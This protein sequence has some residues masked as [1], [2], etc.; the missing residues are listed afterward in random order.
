[1]RGQGRRDR[2][3]VRG[4][5]CLGAH[6]ALPEEAQRA[7]PFEVDVDL[8]LDLRAAGGS[9]DLGAT[10]DYSRICEIVMEVIEGAHSTLMEHLAEQVARRTLV[11]AGERAEGVAVGVRK[12]R[13]PVPV[14][15]ASAGVRIWRWAGP[16]GGGER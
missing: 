8:Y 4:V 15:M 5:R 11:L 3:E 13:P 14:E 2:I 9:D 1:M 16:R 6:G 10:V 7:Q 12:L